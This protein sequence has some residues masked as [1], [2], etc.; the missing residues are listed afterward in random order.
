[1]TLTYQSLLRRRINEVPLR[2]VKAIHLERSRSHS[3]RGSSTVY[4]VVLELA[5]GA[6]LP[7][8]S[9]SSS[10]R[11]GKT[12]MAERLRVFLG[13]EAIDDDTTWGSLNKVTQVV[14]GEMQRQMDA[15][16]GEQV[17]DGIH[18]SI[19]ALKWGPSGVTRWFSPDFQTPG[20]FVFLAQ[21]PEGQNVLSGG[22]FEKLGKAL[23]PQVLQI[24]GFTAEDTP[25]LENAGAL[26]DLDP[27]V[28]A[29][30]SGMA[31]DRGTAMRILNTYATEALAD[32]GRRYPVKQ[33]QRAPI[34][35]QLVILFSPRGVFVTAFGNIIEEAVDEVRDLGVK[36]VKAQ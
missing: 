22:L 34:F 7:L 2:D 14:Q 35:Q 13:L 33:L 9:Y 20:G 16:A 1:L 5:D 25:G 19:Q 21:K 8:R 3:T 6:S 29:H 10:G 28:A 24:Y 32:W 4:R 18:W 17:T 12:R 11:A 31:S 23:T 36:L 27:R 15:A 30:F 26:A